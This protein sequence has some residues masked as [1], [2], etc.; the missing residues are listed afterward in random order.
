MTER[1]DP[2]VMPYTDITDAWLAR[3]DCGCG[4][5]ETHASQSDAEAA[6]DAARTDGDET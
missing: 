6:A 4:L 2:H 3:C 1:H 5:Y